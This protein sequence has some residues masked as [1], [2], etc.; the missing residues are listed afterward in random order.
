MDYQKKAS[1]ISERIKQQAIRDLAED[2][3]NET[4]SA[5]GM[6]AGSVA[7]VAAPMNSGDGMIRRK[8][9]TKLKGKKGSKKTNPSIYE[10]KDYQHNIIP[11]K[12]DPSNPT[13]EVDGYASVDLNTLKSMLSKH[14]E[15]LQQRAEKGQW[16]NLAYL[17]DT[18]V[19]QVKLDALVQAERELEDMQTNEGHYTLPAIDRER[20][21]DIPE[22][23]GPFRMRN[24]MVVYYDPKEGKYYDRDRDMYLSYEE[25]RNANQ[26]PDMK[27]M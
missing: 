1:E 18:Q 19:I 27:V 10:A 3:V 17:L 20:Y 25:Y 6:G 16:S 12:D 22:L 26:D 4:M 11:N 14:F 21:T 9:K 8:P 15:D 5:G 7:S 13:I 2:R 24:G 23:E